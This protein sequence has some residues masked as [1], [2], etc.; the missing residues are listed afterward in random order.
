MQNLHLCDKLVGT[1]QELLIEATLDPFWAAKATLNSKSLKNGSWQGA[2][3]MGKILMEIR[4]EL[5]S[6]GAWSSY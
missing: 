1:G 4:T 5:R 6:Y 2:N 3:F